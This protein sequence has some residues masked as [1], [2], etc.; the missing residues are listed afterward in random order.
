M[1]FAGQEASV[2]LNNGVYNVLYTDGS[3]YTGW[4]YCNGD[5]TL[6]SCWSSETVVIGNSNGGQTGTA[7][8]GFTF[9]D[10][11]TPTLI[12]QYYVD[13]SNNTDVATATIPVSGTTAPT[14][15]K[16]GAVLPVQGGNNSQGNMSVLYSAGTYYMWQESLWSTTNPTEGNTHSWQ[17]GVTTAST[18]TGTFSSIASPLSSIRVG[19]NAGD[20]GPF[21]TT[22]GSTA[23]MIYH[24]QPWGRMVVSDICRATIPLAN[25]G[26]DGWTVT[27]GGVGNST[28]EVY[29]FWMH[30]A[31]FLE[32]DQLADPTIFSS[33]SGVQY[34]MYTAAKN[35]GD[36]EGSGWF[37]QMITPLLSGGTQTDGAYTHNIYGFPGDNPRWWNPAYPDFYT[38]QAGLTL[39]V[40]TGG[41]WSSVTNTSQNGGI[42]YTNTS[43]ASSDQATWRVS[44]LPGTYTISVSYATGPGNGIA[45]FQIYDCVNHVAGNIVNVDGYA[46]SAAYNANATGTLYI[47]GYEP[48]KGCVQMNVNGK[49]ASSTG[50]QLQVSGFSLQRTGQ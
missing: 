23:V 41:T 43:A 18:S 33:A 42:L 44:L 17:I 24:C 48:I 46:A 14:F 49:N 1:L 38:N 45:E 36:G 47:L 9:F 10:P 28:N 3:G 25:V 6:S 16:I 37:Y 7:K 30:R 13:S 40:A 50:Y 32:Y 8:H 19:P 39:P 21:V 4:R 34:L 5:P 31:A 29:P 2:F 35:N 12:N 22:V 15:T 11:A 27:N 26:T 20:G